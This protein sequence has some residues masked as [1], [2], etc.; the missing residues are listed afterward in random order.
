[1]PFK[2]LV[3]PLVLGNP[4]LMKHAPS[5]PLCAEAIE[6]LF[7]DAGFD[8]G[9]YQNLFITNEQ[10]ERVLSDKRVRGVKFTGSTVGGKA[11]AEIAGRNMKQGCYELGGSDPF[12]VLDDADLD[13]AVDKAY[14]SRMVNNAQA[15]INAKRFILLD[16]VYDQFRD[17]LIEKL[18][19]NVKMGDPMDKAV[20]LGP[21]AIKRLT[22]GLRG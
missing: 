6:K 10:A 22:E 12:L 15:C 21:L 17:L 5:T 11:V 16:S 9:E 1:M 4:V 20:T 13:F 7:I 18:E 2:S 14:I 19:N 8:E 3:P